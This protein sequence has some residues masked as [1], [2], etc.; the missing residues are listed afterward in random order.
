MGGNEKQFLNY[1]VLASKERKRELGRGRG[2]RRQAQNIY[3]DS[4]QFTLNS[5]RVKKKKKGR[6]RIKLETDPVVKSHPA[7]AQV[8]N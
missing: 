3:W 4:L 7:G 2:S 6:E 1:M 5:W 8:R